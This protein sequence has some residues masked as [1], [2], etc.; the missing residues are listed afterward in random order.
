[1]ESVIKTW[2]QRKLSPNKGSSTESPLEVAEISVF[3]SSTSQ[4]ASYIEVTNSFTD[5]CFIV[6]TFKLTN[7]SFSEFST[8]KLSF[9]SVRQQLGLEVDSLAHHE[10]LY[11]RRLLCCLYHSRESNQPEIIKF[12]LKTLLS[13]KLPGDD[14]AGP[15][16]QQIEIRIILSRQ[17][18][19][20]LLVLS[21]SGNDSRIGT[22]MLPLFGNIALSSLSSKLHVENQQL[23]SESV[24]SMLDLTVESV[25]T[26]L[27]RILPLEETLN[28]GALAE[29]KLAI[30]FQT[31]GT[32]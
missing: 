12:E 15:D 9:A 13:T 14:G 24:T 16:K 25:K 2:E 21:N 11:L 17:K 19:I 30:L 10:N 28:I 6:K 32:K 1:M 7:S 18:P 8:Q 5:K 4:P 29:R 26:K 3:L 22:L 31:S 23:L 20:G 27:G